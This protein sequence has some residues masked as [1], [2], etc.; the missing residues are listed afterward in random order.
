MNRIKEPI[1]ALTHLFGACLSLIALIFMIFQSL[2]S[3]LQM[4]GAIVFGFSMIGLYM[5]STIYHWVSSTPKVEDFLRKLDHSMIYILIAGTYT[6][7]CLSAITN[8]SIRLLLGTV[9]LLAILGIITKLFWLHA[10][11]WLYTG[12]YIAMGWTAILFF[13]PILTII[14][15]KALAW[16]LIGGILYTIGGIIYATKPKFLE[17]KSMGFH[18]IFH[19]FIL[20]GSLSHFIVISGYIY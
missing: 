6:P 19:I 15:F 7:I 18:E 8:T 12:F 11:R 10:P 1:N 9:W 17:M 14:S 3:P 2:D 5:A 16:L 4:V 13:K 20:L